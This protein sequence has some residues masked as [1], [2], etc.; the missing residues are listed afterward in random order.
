[1][2]RSPR[3]DR[4]ARVE[5]LI[6]PSVRA[7]GYALVRLKMM[8]GKTRP[9]LQ[10]MA[11][12]DD[13]VEMTV[14]DCAQ[15]SRAISA[16]LDV[17][18]PIPSAYQLEVSSP[19][20]DRPLVRLEDFERF[21]GHVAKVEL[22][23]PIDGRKRYRGRLLGR[24][25]EVVRIALEDGEGPVAELPFAEVSEAKLV[26]TDELIRAALKESERR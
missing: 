11:E 26:L 1:M 18:D 5:E 7:L 24:E 14:D 4:L 22:A 17:E 12:R 3:Q 16:L 21:A 23:R 13:G 20:I 9:T 6:A 8:G 19:G 2:D 15:L 10:I 25:G